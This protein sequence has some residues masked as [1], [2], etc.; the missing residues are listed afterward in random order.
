MNT[1]TK[2]ILSIKGKHLRGIRWSL[3]LYYSLHGAGHGLHQR[4]FLFLT[5]SVF[6]LLTFSRANHL[7]HI[8]AGSGELFIQ[9]L[10]HLWIFQLY[11]IHGLWPVY[12]WRI[13]TQFSQLSPHLIYQPFSPML[14]TG[15]ISEKGNG[16]GAENWKQISILPFKFGGDV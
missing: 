14:C 3:P 6:T 12:I 1:D 4:K 13:F 15:F 8:P 5:C 9:D 2:L 11:D 10:V 16:N 7:P